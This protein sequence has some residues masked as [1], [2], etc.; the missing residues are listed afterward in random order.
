MIGPKGRRAALRHDSGQMRIGIVTPFFPPHVG[1]LEV[2]AAALAAEFARRHEV[3]VVACSPYGADYDDSGA[4]YEVLRLPTA[5]PTE[6][7]GVPYPIPIG[8]GLAEA[9]RRLATCDLLHV[10]GVLFAPSILSATYG[11]WLG[12]PTVLME[13]AGWTHYRSRLLRAV[14]RSAWRCVGVPMMRSVN[15]VTT[16]STRIAGFLS[17]ISGDIPPRVIANG[18]DTRRFRPATAEQRAD[19][20][21]Q[22]GLPTNLPIALFAGRAVDKKGVSDIRCLTPAGYTLL[23]CGDDHAELAGTAR[24]LGPVAHDRMPQLLAAADVLLHPAHGEGITLTIKEAMA[25]GVPVVMRWDASHAADLPP[26][27]VVG[28]NAANDL[29]PALAELLSNQDHRGTLARVGR[30]WAESHWGWTAIAD[31]YLSLF[32]NVID[33]S[34][35]TDG[36]RLRQ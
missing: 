17:E 13:H 1:G 36:S 34:R 19:A 7:A 32:A 30:D 20:K 26:D 15:A 24:N 21:R 35:S 11:R 10:H 2:V 5:A 31:E 23:S 9:R 33:E 12:I 4:L 16:H 14:Q 18:V 22:L 3:V 27:T 25:A 8:P 29:A 28:Y 6:R